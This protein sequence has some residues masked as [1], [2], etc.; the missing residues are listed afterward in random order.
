VALAQLLAVTWSDALG[1][2]VD[3]PFAG[4]GTLTRV[5]SGVRLHPVTP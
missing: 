3:D 5:V 4:Q 2:A 1:L